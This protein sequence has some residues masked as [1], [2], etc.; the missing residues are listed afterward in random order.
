[1]RS[2]TNAR[3]RSLGRRFRIV[4][5]TVETGAHHIELLRPESSEALISEADF[6]RDERLPYWAE[7]WPSALILARHIATL[8]GA[9][10]SMLELG[11][12]VGL[13]ATAGMLAGFTVTATDYYDDALLF[14]GANVARNTGREPALRPL[15]WRALPHDLGLFDV[16]VAS[17]VLYEREYPS[18]IAS[19][20]AR[21]LAARGVAIIADPG[22]VAAPAL[23]EACTDHGLI[24]T[25]R[26]SVPFEEGAIRQTIDL[27]TIRRAR[28]GRA[29]THGHMQSA[30]GD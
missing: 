19:V 14:A 15:D 29:H 11:C 23:P 30:R 1:L 25:R 16:I 21:A 20:L 9:G 28:E 26:R 10:R 18:L 22:R 17:D 5:V 2:S 6:E 27:L 7:L 8:E 3:E 13:V 12:G 24:V 4:T